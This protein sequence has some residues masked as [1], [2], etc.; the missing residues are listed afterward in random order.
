M[1]RLLLQPGGDVFSTYFFFIL[2][3]LSLRYFFPPPL[4]SAH[5][6][7]SLVAPPSA[8]SSSRALPWR[9][10]PS[11]S[12]LLPSLQP[13]RSTRAA[14]PSCREFFFPAQPV[15]AAPSHPNGAEGELRRPGAGA[16]FQRRAQGRALRASF[17]RV[18]GSSSGGAPKGG[19]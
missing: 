6:P 5:G 19:R 2:P 3:S 15:V 10:R 4:V 12:I 9:R 16:K 8:H 17:G 14:Q 11:S 7:P 13:L 1:T 18:P